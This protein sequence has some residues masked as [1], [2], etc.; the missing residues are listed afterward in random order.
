[1]TKN[2]NKSIYMI[3]ILII[4]IQ[5]GIASV[6]ITCD[7]TEQEI[8]TGNTGNYTT[9]ITTTNPGTHTLSF[10]TPNNNITARLH[11]QGNTTGNF[12]TEGT[13][14]WTAK[15][16][17]TSYNFTLEVKPTNK[18]TTNQKYNITIRD[19]YL[20]TPSNNSI[21]GLI[22]TNPPNPEIGA[23]MLIG[24]I[25]LTLIHIKRNR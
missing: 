8:N 12:S 19:T 13:L 11:G 4:V 3:A 1:M 5:P 9:I 6:K 24:I 7:P 22:P 21:A 25:L 18:T 10:K 2:L 17:R 20:Q 23:L 15:P 16:T 14:T